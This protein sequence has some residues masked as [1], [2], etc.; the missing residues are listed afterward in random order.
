MALCDESWCKMDTALKETSVYEDAQQCQKETSCAVTVGCG[1][2]YLLLKRALDMVISAVGLVALAIPML[3]VMVLIRVDSP[4]PAIF[5]QDRMGKDGKPF[6]IYKFRTMR[7]H[8]P[9]DVAS[10]ELHNSEQYI[11]KFGAFL[12]RSSIDEL[13]QLLNIL[14]GDMS[15]I[16]Y[17][18]VCLT[19]E[20]LND[21]RKEYGVFALR[22]G[23]TGLA[24]ASGRDNVDYQQKALLDAQYVKTCSFK[25]DWNCLVKTIKV[26][27]SGEGV[28]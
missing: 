24:Q 23:I 5:K 12:R 4:G 1:S 9:K 15:F 7:T 11:T 17:R 20:K 27:I 19:E 26:V 8:A 21:L 3:I 13:P 22:P 2:G 6:I 28:N 10:C 25:T 16:G 18:P 14:K